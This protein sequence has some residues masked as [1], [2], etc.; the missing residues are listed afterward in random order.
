METPPAANEPGQLP[1]VLGP[2]IA[3]A[4]V[5]GT[6]IGSGVFKKP[7]AVAKDISEFGL[8]MIAW[9]L[10][11]AL[12]LIGSLI[13]AEVAVIHPRAGGNYVFLREGYGRWA[14]FLWGW[15]EFWIIRTG[16]IGALAGVF[17]ESVFDIAAYLVRT[18]PTEDP[19][20]VAD[21]K[22]FWLRQGVTITVI[23]VLAIVNARG[24][25]L[26]GGLQLLVTTVKCVSLVGIA[27]M[28]F[29]FLA[30]VSEP[31]VDAARLEPIWPADAGSINWSKFGSAMV[32]ILWAYHGWM[33]LAPMAEE[34][35][36]P[37]RNLPLSFVMGTMAIIVLYLSVNVAYHL[38][39]PRD[40][41][42]AMGGTSPVAT[43]FAQHLLGPVGLLF[44]SM[45]IMISVFGSLNGNLLV[46]PRLL[47]AMGKDGLA[48]KSLCQLHATFRT[49]V[50]AVFVLAGWAILLV[51]GL[52]MLSFF[53]DD[54]NKMIADLDAQCGD[55]G[56]FMYFQIPNKALFDV[57][58][59]YVMFGAVAFE[60][61]AVASIFVVRRQYPVDKVALPYR[62][63]GYPVL[64]IVYV[65]VMAAVLGNMFY[66]Q[67]TES[68][69]AMGFIG[70]G[71]AVYAVVFA[72]R[73]VPV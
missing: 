7:H 60:T 28:P 23:A 37:N 17:S 66:T 56:V 41:I 5:I 24:T 59:D 62:C 11:G 31:D 22:F 15:V 35:K 54:L 49:P 63:W 8:I 69:I 46:G 65:A 36:N 14:G 58:T 64:P 67:R 57:V 2:W 12:A 52:G 21:P 10:V 47:F 51:L 9:V 27:I 70:V 68:L 1:R 48:P 42:I 71:A 33:N 25:I 50:I 40:E 45:A 32:G 38:V 44:G 3:T 18:S 43:L 53:R 30:L 55:I 4:I 6:V 39:V 61:L 19:F 20:P 16:S 29:L 72:R 73:P 26:G 13:L 34:V